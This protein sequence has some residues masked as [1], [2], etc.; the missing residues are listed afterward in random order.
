MLDI[1]GFRAI[2]GQTVRKYPL[3]RINMQKDV[4][5]VN[6]KRLTRTARRAVKHWASSSFCDK[7]IVIRAGYD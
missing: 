5:K 2:S 4:W 3:P 7:I 6:E 1:N